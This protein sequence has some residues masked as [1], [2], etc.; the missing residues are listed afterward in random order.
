MKQNYIVNVIGWR[1]FKNKVIRPSQLLWHYQIVENKI[2]GDMCKKQNGREENLVAFLIAAVK[3]WCSEFL[4]EDL[5]ALQLI[6][7]L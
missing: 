4:F 5:E 1:L 7:E 3:G 6:L 2:T